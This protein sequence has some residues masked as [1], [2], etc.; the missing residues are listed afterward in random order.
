MENEVV[1]NDQTKAV[2]IAAP[3]LIFT[4]DDQAFKSDPT[5]IAISGHTITLAG[6]LVSLESEIVRLEP[7]MKSRF[8]DELGYG[9][10]NG[11][12]TIYKVRGWW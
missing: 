1:R 8:G 9:F 12:S 4:I 11:L 6:T 10:A 3:R 7:V 2:L 5:S